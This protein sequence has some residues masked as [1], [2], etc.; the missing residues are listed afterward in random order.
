MSKISIQKNKHY[1]NVN[2]QNINRNQN[3]YKNNPSARNTNQVKN[4]QSVKDS[5]KTP[6][7]KSE[8][9]P[10]GR[11]RRRRSAVSN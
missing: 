5:V 4:N 1:P 11:T 9:A 10:A 2:N 8:E 7:A 3:N 6:L